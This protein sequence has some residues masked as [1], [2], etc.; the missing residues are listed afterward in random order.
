MKTILKKRNMI[1]GFIE[2]GK[3]KSLLSFIGVIE[4]EWRWF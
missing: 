1:Q 3:K 2:T 4:E